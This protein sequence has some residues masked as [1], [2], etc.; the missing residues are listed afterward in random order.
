MPLQRLLGVRTANVSDGG[1]RRWPH[2]VSYG[3]RASTLASVA[4]HDAA[5]RPVAF[6]ALEDAA[7]EAGGNASKHV[8]PNA[9][10]HRPAQVPLRQP[11]AAQDEAST[12]MQT[13]VSAQVCTA[14]EQVGS[15]AD[16]QVCGLD[17]DFEDDLDVLLGGSVAAARQQAGM[18]ATDKALLSAPLDKVWATTLNA[19]GPSYRGQGEDGA[20]CEHDVRHGGSARFSAQKDAEIHTKPK[21]AQAELEDWLDL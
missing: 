15:A 1:V 6:S 20:R 4:R 9:D 19:E 13:R 18:G 16:S 17:V 8:G 12:V 21:G 2:G 3:K 10:K 7:H 11:A 14:V 5:A